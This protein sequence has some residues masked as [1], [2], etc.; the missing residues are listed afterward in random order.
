MTDPDPRQTLCSLVAG[1]GEPIKS[2]CCAFSKST[3]D[4]PM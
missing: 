4:I 1:D 3:N 2:A